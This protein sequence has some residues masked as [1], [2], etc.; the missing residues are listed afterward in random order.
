MAAVELPF[1]CIARD[2]VSTVV[3]STRTRDGRLPQMRKA[4]RTEAALDR[5]RKLAT[6]AICVLRRS[7]GE[8]PRVP[9]WLPRSELCTH[10]GN[11]KQPKL[12]VS[13]D[14]P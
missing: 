7:Q 6:H 9:K 1:G 5:S 10:W 11:A 13:R 8:D 2:L 3:E 4:E 14:R 12:R